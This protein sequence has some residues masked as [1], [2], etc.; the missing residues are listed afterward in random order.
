MHST[1]FTLC[2]LHLWIQ[3]SDHSGKYRHFWWVYSENW[4]LLAFH[5]KCQGQMNAYYASIWN[6]I[7]RPFKIIIDWNLDWLLSKKYFSYRPKNWYKVN[8][9]TFEMKTRTLKDM[10]VIAIGWC[11]QVSSLTTNEWL[12]GLSFRPVNV[13][14]SIL[15]L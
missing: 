1:H 6:W 15:W 7:W 10:R 5:F 14:R 4:N 9:R 13:K 12:T 8:K 3:I 11:V 2:T